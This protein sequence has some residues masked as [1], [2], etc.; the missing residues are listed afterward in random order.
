MLLNS[1]SMTEDGIP[2]KL[3]NLK[4][5]KALVAIKRKRINEDRVIISSLSSKIDTTY[6]HCVHTIDDLEDHGLVKTEKKGRRREIYLTETGKQY[7]ERVEFILEDE[8]GDIFSDKK[9]DSVDSIELFS[10]Q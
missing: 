4:P 7:A 6:A 3:L 1:Y 5:C 8:N 10:K 2:E 9:E